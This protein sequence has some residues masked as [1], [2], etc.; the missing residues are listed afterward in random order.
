MQNLLVYRQRGQNSQRPGVIATT[1]WPQ[2]RTVLR[3]L[4]KQRFVNGFR[5]P[6]ALPFSCGRAPKATDRQSAC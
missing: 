2:C 4:V 5:P 6:N 1:H 3:P